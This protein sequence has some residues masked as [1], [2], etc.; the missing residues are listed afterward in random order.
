[1]KL[2]RTSSVARS[3]AVIVLAGTTLAAPA[4]GADPERTAFDARPGDAADAV[5]G[6]ATRQLK[7]ALGDQGLLS[8]DPYSGT[9]RAAAKLD[10]A[11]TAPSRRDGEDC[12][13]PRD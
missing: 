10:G 1:M 4:Y 6:K 11:L 3:A 8:A 12:R 2:L 7:R 13:A 9:V 5:P